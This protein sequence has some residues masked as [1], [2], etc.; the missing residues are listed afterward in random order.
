M[1]DIKR[2]RYV[3]PIAEEWLGLV[4]K[5]FHEPSRSYIELPSKRDDILIHMLTS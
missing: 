5:F 2:G 1:I 3:N 4:K